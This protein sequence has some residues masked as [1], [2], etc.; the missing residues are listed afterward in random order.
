M[1]ATTGGTGQ[2]MHCPDTSVSGG[3]ALASCAQPPPGVP[4]NPLVAPRPAVVGVVVALAAKPAVI[5]PAAVT[6]VATLHQL[7]VLGT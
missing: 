7:G 2:H 3:V 4:A 1:P 6:V 5:M